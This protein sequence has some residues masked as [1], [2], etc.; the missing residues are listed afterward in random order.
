M[1]PVM[2]HPLPRGISERAS[3]FVK[4]IAWNQKLNSGMI[5]AITAYFTV[6]SAV[7]FYIYG[8]GFMLRNQ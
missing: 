6:E 8:S 5:V 4:S 3:Y 1:L 7:H 2:E